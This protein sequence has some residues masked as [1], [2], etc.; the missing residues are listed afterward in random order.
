MQDSS[1]VVFPKVSVSNGRY[2]VYR[3]AGFA[4]YIKETIL[5]FRFQNVEGSHCFEHCG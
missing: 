4:Y 1:P 5:L 2:K 3:L